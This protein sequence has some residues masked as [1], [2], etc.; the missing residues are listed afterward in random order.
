MENHTPCHQGRLREK[1]K[2]TT[3]ATVVFLDATMFRMLP[4]VY[5]VARTH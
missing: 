1:I 2:G 3:L 4:K 5:D